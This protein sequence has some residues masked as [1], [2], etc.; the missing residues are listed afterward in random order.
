MRQTWK[1]QRRRTYCAVYWDE[2]RHNN[3][4]NADYRDVA[5]DKA[6]E[7]KPPLFV[8][9]RPQELDFLR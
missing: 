6:S 4:Q 8:V 3:W 9:G 5:I 7:R 2:I 1:G